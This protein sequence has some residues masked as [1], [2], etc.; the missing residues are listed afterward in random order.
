MCRISE[1]ENKSGIHNFD[2]Q[3]AILQIRGHT[4]L[5]T[6]MHLRSVVMIARQRS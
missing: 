4:M 1:G 2:T 5:V 3:S 6:R